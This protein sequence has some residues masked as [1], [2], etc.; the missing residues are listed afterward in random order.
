MKNDS[1]M[2]RFSVEIKS[3]DELQARVCSSFI[4]EY[5]ELYVFC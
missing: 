2:K 3:T 1:Q 5:V 4:L